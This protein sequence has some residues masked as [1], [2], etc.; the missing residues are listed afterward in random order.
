MNFCQIETCS[1][2]NGTGFR[3]VLWCSGCPHHCKGCHNPETWQKDAGR[4]FTDEDK[5]KLFE[6]LSYPYIQ[7]ITFSGGD[8]LFRPNLDTV[9]A[10]MQE[11]KTK[12]PDKDIW[13]YT[14]Y[15]FEELQRDVERKKFLPYIDVLVDGK[16]I[17]EQRD[18]TIAFRGSHN[19]RI[20]NVP[21]TLK[22][23]KIVLKMC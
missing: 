21:E 16:F 12:F 10:L 4:E 15:T 3:V 20:I 2:A 22:Q 23:N 9:Y 19:Q 1:I 6:L 18:I 5:Q 17:L 8:P 14:G 7:G 13:L 11:I